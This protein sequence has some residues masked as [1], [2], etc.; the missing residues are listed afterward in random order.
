ME[1]DE[2]R[3]EKEPAAFSGWRELLADKLELPKDVVLDLPRLVVVGNLQLIIENHRGI[4][5]YTADQ[6]VVAGH[7]GRLR[8]GG[9][10]LTIGSIQEDLIIVTGELR[11][12]VFDA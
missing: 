12:I 1:P 6:V 7:K 5:E 9:S 3:C 4:V 2:N 11:S 8:I 10:Q